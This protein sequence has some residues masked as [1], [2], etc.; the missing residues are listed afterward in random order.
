MPVLASL[1]VVALLVAGGM[2]LVLGTYDVGLF[3]AALLGGTAAA[4]AGA[5]ATAVAQATLRR[6]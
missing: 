6:R 3:V 4:V 1:M 2:L 5:C